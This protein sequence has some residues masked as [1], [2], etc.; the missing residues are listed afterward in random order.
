MK[1]VVP[2]QRSSKNNFVA[3]KCNTL[4]FLRF[5]T[6]LLLRFDTALLLH[7][8]ITLLLRFNAALLLRDCVA[9]S[10]R[11]FV[12]SSLRHCVASSLR[13][14]DTALLLHYNTTLFLR[15]NTS[16]FFAT[17]CCFFAS[18]LRHCVASSLRHFVAS[19]LQHFVVLLR[20]DIVLLLRLATLICLQLLGSLICLSQFYFV[21]V[22][23]FGVH[24]VFL[25]IV[26]LRLFAH[27]GCFCRLF[28][29]SQESVHHHT[30]SRGR[31]HRGG[32][33][34]S[35][36]SF[37]Q[38]HLFFVPHRCVNYTGLFPLLARRINVGE[39]HWATSSRAP[40]L[41][42]TG[43]FS[44]IP[45]YWE[46]L[47]DILSRNK[48][49]LT[50]A[51]I[52]GAVRASLFTYDRNVHAMQA[53]FE[54]WCPATNTL[55]TSVGEI[56]I[57]LWDLCRIGGLPLFGSFYDEV[58]PSAKEMSSLPSS[59]EYLFAAF[60]HL[61][62]KLGGPDSVTS[63]EW[64]G[65][66]FRG[67]VRYP[68]PPNRRSLRRSVRGKLSHNPRGIITTHRNQCRTEDEETPFR[69]LKVSEKAKEETWLAALLSCWLGEF[70]FPGKEANL[71]RPGT[72]QGRKLNGSWLAPLDPCMVRFSGEG[73][74]KYF[75]EAE[76]R[77]LFCS[78]T[79]FKFHRLALFKG[80]QEILEDNDQLSDSYV[81]YFIS[82][83]PSYLSSRRGDLSVLE[84][85]SP[86]RFGRQFGFT[87]DIPGE[88]KEDLRAAPLERVMHLWHRC[89]RINTKGAD[90]AMASHAKKLNEEDGISC[91]DHGNEVSR[92]D[93]DRHWRR[94]KYK[95]NVIDGANH[96]IVMKTTEPF[97]DVDTPSPFSGGDEQVSLSSLFDSA[98]TESVRALC[99]LFNDPMVVS[100]IQELVEDENLDISLSQVGVDSLKEVDK[101]QSPVDGS[102]SM[103]EFSVQGL[104]TFDLAT[105]VI[106]KPH[107]EKSNASIP[108][109]GPI[110][111][112]TKDMVSKVR[113][114][115]IPTASTVST[116]NA[117]DVISKASRH[118]AFMLGEGLIEKIIKT[119]FDSVASLKEEV[120]NQRRADA[121]RRYTLALESEAIEARD[122]S[123]AEAELSKVL[124]KETELRKELELLAT[125]RGKLENSISLHEEKLPQLQAAVS[126]IK[127]EISEIEATPTLETSDHAKLQELRELLETSREELK[128]LD[129]IGRSSF[130]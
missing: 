85:Y 21:T 52:Y 119:P 3:D 118:Y 108:P 96:E 45:K 126:R 32:D 41:Q 51:K 83:R 66:W 5:D 92:N 121:E 102:P 77:K 8:N 18:T 75:E 63:T 100:A 125:Q 33:N 106:E 80:H 76:A 16:S 42:Y 103:S 60:H 28:E 22:T 9:S 57:T 4:L 79:K 93:S 110:C 56:S 65:F 99:C 128:N 107:L 12:A 36:S 117:E 27:N 122:S 46:W 72:F 50:D 17:L 54:Y 15:F 55:H 19:S 38:F 104:E 69:I 109:S 90:R 82:Q 23:Y 111:N 48:K 95:D 30:E 88:I 40:P 58:V 10:L 64:V 124:S 94:R 71:I 113:S 70:V 13:H 31:T 2:C 114:S 81:D 78:I 24:P 37:C 73:A 25:F 98:N 47:E 127:E 130:M 97:I 120:K 1:L 20:F 89:L 11:H 86:H 61:S 29:D 115:G 123:R 49:T 67:S 34:F 105:K 74:A 116:L 39:A 91:S 68:K 53:F 43:E 84:P 35:S 14:F 44:Y 101:R 62:L 7:Y 129:W 112:P 26:V 6:S 87:Q 59:C